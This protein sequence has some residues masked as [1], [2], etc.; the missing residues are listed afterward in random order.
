MAFWIPYHIWTPHHHHHPFH[1]AD[2]FKHFISHLSH[3]VLLSTLKGE[4]RK[5]LIA[6][7]KRDISHFR[8]CIK[9]VIIPSPLS[10]QFPHFPAFHSFS[11]SPFPLPLRKTTIWYYNDMIYTIWYIQWYIILG[12]HFSCAMIQL[13]KLFCKPSV[14]CNWKLLREGFKNPFTESVHKGGTTPRLQKVSFQEFPD[15]DSMHPSLVRHTFG[16]PF[17]QR[18]WDLK[19][20]Q[21]D[22]VL[23]DMVDDIVAN[24]EIHKL[25]D[26]VADM[27][28]D[29]KK[30]LTLIWTW[31]PTWR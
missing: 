23:A 30:W 11:L 19:K 4:G 1:L 12:L 14:W 24:I 2:D 26:I 28:A 27:K 7:I 13:S 17:C 22:I 29:K 5:W 9:E 10:P 18:L 20:R 3:H 21:D 15:F 8:S 16:F 31:W 25:A 6:L